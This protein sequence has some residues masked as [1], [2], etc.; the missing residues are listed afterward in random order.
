MLDNLTEE[1]KIELRSNPNKLGFEYSNEDF[2]GYQH[3]NLFFDIF[4][5]NKDIDEM[6]DRIYNKKV[7]TTTIFIN[8]DVIKITFLIELIQ[9]FI[10]INLFVLGKFESK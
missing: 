1:E 9:Q 3:S 10:L 8:F 2:L 7:F 6:I 4:N 5:D